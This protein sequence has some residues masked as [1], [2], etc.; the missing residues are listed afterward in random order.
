MYPCGKAKES[1]TNIV[2]DSTMYKEERH[3]LEEEM[4]QIDE[5]GMKNFSTLDNSEKTIALLGD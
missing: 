5:C 4:K 1:I 2:G 3:V